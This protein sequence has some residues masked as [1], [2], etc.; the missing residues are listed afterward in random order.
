MGRRNVC[1]Y[2]SAGLWL[3]FQQGDLG[4]GCLRQIAQMCVM[5][6][7]DHLPLFRHLGPQAEGGIARVSSKRSMMSST[8]KGTGPFWAT[9]S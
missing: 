9:N 1:P 3:Q 7:I 6:Q 2:A 5:G 4:A 8:M